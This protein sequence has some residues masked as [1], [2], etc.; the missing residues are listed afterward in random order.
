MIEI[1]KVVDFKVVGDC[2]LWLRFSD[3]QEGVCDFSDLLAEGG[4]MVD[5]LRDPAMFRRVFLSFGVPS[6]PNG[7]DLD[8]INLHRKLEQAGALKRVAAA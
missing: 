4:P 1:V 7:L 2:S 5:P 3:G 8:A 6:W